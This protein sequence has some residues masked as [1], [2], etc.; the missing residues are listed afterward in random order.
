MTTETNLGWD[1]PKS[2]CAVAYDFD[3]AKVAKGTRVLFELFW[4][5]K[6]FAPRADGLFEGEFLRMKKTTRETCTGEKEVCFSPLF[7]EPGNPTKTF[8]AGYQFAFA[9]DPDQ[10]AALLSYVAE[11]KQQGE[12][13]RQEKEAKRVAEKLRRDEESRQLREQRE[14]ELRTKADEIGVSYEDLV[15]G[16]KQWDQLRNKSFSPNRC[17][18][19]NRVLTDPVSIKTGI[20]PECVKDIPKMLA[21]MKSNAVDIGKLRYRS[22]Q[23]IERLTRAGFDAMADMV[24]EGTSC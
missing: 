21:A 18:I 12:V 4:G 20:G 1:S 23:L 7:C 3:W 24:K 5:S 14:Q 2:N 17:F 6:K 19:C 13:A 9:D 10:V 8:T 15:D 11:K 22:Q 16:C